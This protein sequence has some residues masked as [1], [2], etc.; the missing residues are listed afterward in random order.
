MASGVQDAVQHCAA[1]E[2]RFDSLRTSHSH[3]LDM[4][5]MLEIIQDILSYVYSL[6]PCMEMLSSQL[7]RPLSHGIEIQPTWSG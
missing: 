2:W 4:N 6:G 1:H 7:T 3:I 5:E